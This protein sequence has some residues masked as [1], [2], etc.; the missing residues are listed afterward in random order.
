M[1]GARGFKLGQTPTYKD[2]VGAW[3]PGGST[4]WD[5]FITISVTGAKD[6]V[7]TVTYAVGID[8]NRLML[9]AIDPE[10]VPSRIVMQR[11]ARS[12][13][14]TF[15]G[16]KLNCSCKSSVDCKHIDAVHR[17][18]DMGVFQCQTSVKLASSSTR[19]STT[20]SRA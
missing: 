1:I 6:R 12:Y 7:E 4:G 8:G 14:V 10:N 19:T 16:H 15:L 5:G 3:L 11:A 2:R 20:S 13:W 17:L 9:Q 18:A